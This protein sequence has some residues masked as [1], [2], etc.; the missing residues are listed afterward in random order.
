MTK[1]Q[2][3]AIGLAAL[4]PRPMT[5]AARVDLVERTSSAMTVQSRGKVDAAKQRNPGR[6]F[7]EVQTIYHEARRAVPCHATGSGGIL[8]KQ[9]WLRK[10]QREFDRR[11]REAGVPVEGL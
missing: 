5:H 9:Y 11:L 7:H 10:V 6:S 8:G 2:P 3:T 1:A 4:Q